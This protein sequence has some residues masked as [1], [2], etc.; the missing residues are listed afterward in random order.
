MGLT[1][2]LF[3]RIETQEAKEEPEASGSF[4]VS[5]SGT[6]VVVGEG[7]PVG[8]RSLFFLLHPH[9]AG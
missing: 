5:V 1:A 9:P 3:H 8:G 7:G 2:G 4:E 6:I